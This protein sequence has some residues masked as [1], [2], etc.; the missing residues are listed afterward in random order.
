MV[1][2]NASYQL[3]QRIG[4]YYD[5]FVKDTISCEDYDNIYCYG[6]YDSHVEIPMLSKKYFSARQLKEETAFAV[7]NCAMATLANKFAG[8]E[9]AYTKPYFIFFIRY[10]NICDKYSVIIREAPDI[11]SPSDMAE[12][13]A[14]CLGA[15]AKQVIAA[16]RFGYFNS[17]DMAEVLAKK[18]FGATY[19][20]NNKQLIITAS[21]TTAYSETFR[22]R[23]SVH[24]VNNEEELN[25]AKQYDKFIRCDLL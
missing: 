8:N 19:D 3:Q 20:K 16:E 18:Y 11:I 7:V 23:L 25:H 6:M 1:Y 21:F 9:S 5:I 13:V 2:I 22:G 4:G 12:G 15:R 10:G 14:A 17:K 24:E